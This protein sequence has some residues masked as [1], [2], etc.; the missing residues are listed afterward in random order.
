MQIKGA[1]AMKRETI[2]QRVCATLVVAIGVGIVWGIV[3]AWCGTVVDGW[4]RTPE[5]VYER[6]EVTQNGTVINSS[7][8]GP[9]YSEVTYRTL[10][11]TTVE[12]GRDDRLTAATLTEPVRRRSLFEPGFG[13]GQSL[14]A[15]DFRRPYAGWY[16]MRNRQRHGRAYFIGYDTSTRLPVGYISRSGFRHSLPPEEDWFDVGRER[17]RW[18]SGIAASTGHLTLNTPAYRNSPYADSPGIPNWLVYLIDGEQLLEI[19]LRERTVR[20]VEESPGM[21][22]IGILTEAISPAGD[23][24]PRPGDAKTTTRL[25]LRA[26]DRVV[27]M[28]PPADQRREFPLPE[29]LRGEQLTA[30]SLPT[31]ELLLAWTPDHR[32]PRDAR[33]MWIGSDGKVLGEES[34]KLAFTR[35]H[36]S[37]Q[38]Q[39][40]LIAGLAPVP[41]GWYLG[42]G[43]VAPLGQ[44]A[45]GRAADYEAALATSLDVSWI[46]LVIVTLVGCASAWL[47]WRWQRKYHRP[48]TRVWCTFVFLFGLP[49]LAAYWFEHRRTNLEACGDCGQ[50]VPRD[51]DA[52]AA[53]EVP[54][55]APAQVGTEVFA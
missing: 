3:A 51:R 25:V 34:P 43:V 55:P 20:T 46:A 21:I 48:A 53:C 52:C 38:T 41:L 5:R 30:Y 27:V 40:M 39:A 4:L 18:G 24:V 17:F 45:I 9:G 33:L 26:R 42:A 11:G 32:G 7:R 19:D 29:S 22:S 15:S 10:D 23:G 47:V 35:D 14:S 54:F 31:G 12:P 6:L 37:L 2:L 16:L 13:W 36:Y 50:L 49:A 28:D 44:V 8:Y 1:G